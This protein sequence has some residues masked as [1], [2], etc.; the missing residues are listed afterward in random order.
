[1]NLPFNELSRVIGLRQ[2]EKGVAVVSRRGVF[3]EQAGSH[4]ISKGYLLLRP[5]EQKF[6]LHCR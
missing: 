1:L 3:E 6:D 4:N 2:H 5:F